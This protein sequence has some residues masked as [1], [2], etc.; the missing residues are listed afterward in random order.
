M[1][2]EEGYKSKHPNVGTM[3]RIS[4][5]AAYREEYM[6]ETGEPPIW[7]TACNRMGVNYRTAQRHAPELAANWY[8]KDFRV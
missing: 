1:P 4:L 6:K 5:L 8:D 2:R 7:T 3:R